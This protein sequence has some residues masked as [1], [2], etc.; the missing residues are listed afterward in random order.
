MNF[1]IG[2]KNK[3]DAYHLNGKPVSRKQLNG[4]WMMESVGFSHSNLYH[5]VKQGL[6]SNLATRTDQGRLK[7]VHNLAATKV[8]VD[9]K[10][11]SQEEELCF[12]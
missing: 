5:I 4:M 8:Y 1:P 12:F 3:K 11:E 6:I 9:K 10:K 7:I 2:T